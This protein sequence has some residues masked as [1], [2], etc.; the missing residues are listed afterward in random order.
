[1]L[2]LFGLGEPTLK[3][4][5]AFRVNLK[6]AD[7]SAEIRLDINNFRFG[8]KNSVTG[9]DFYENESLRRKRIHH[10]EVAAVKA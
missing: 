2:V 5:F 9:R 6:E 1:M 7:T 3:D 8:L 10:V 4:G